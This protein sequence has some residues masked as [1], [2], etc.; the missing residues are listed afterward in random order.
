MMG[1]QMGGRSDESREENK[2]KT[3]G[4]TRQKKEK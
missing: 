3:E 1:R 2:N 4:K